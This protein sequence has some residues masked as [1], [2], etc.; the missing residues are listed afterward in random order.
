MARTAGSAA[1]QTRRRI[2]DAATE[3]FN[4]RG[5]AGTS[6]RD[7]TERL[8][9]TKGALYYHFASKDELLHAMVAPLLDAVATFVGTVGDAGTVRPELVRRLV[10]ILDANA[11]LVRSLGS[12]PAVTRSKLAGRGVTAPFAELERSFS[13]SMG[14]TATIRVRCALA[15]IFASVLGPPRPGQLDGPGDRGPGRR[16]TVPEKQFVT[17]AALAV[18]A[19]PVPQSS[20]ETPPPGDQAQATD[21]AP[22]S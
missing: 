21:P 14:E 17:A 2:L 16:L 1:D 7:I 3:L 9:M 13:C 15:L 20:D 10:D 6:I 12:D 22:A 18:L 4:E 19:V 5:Y 8:G 11:P